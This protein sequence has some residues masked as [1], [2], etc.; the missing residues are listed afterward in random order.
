MNIEGIS[1][2]L[3][4][5]SSLVVESGEEIMKSRADTIGKKGGDEVRIKERHQILCR[6]IMVQQII[7]K[8]RNSKDRKC[9]D[10]LNKPPALRSPEEQDH[11]GKYKKQDKVGSHEGHK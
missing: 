2:I 5:V 8:S 9:D 1:H 3:Q 11:K 7:Y 6:Q 10:A 4:K